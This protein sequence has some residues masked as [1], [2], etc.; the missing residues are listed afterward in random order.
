MIAHQIA[1]NGGIQQRFPQKLTLSVSGRNGHEKI[2][3][4]EATTSNGPAT[5]GNFTMQF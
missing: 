2:E 4:A 1:R 5:T 3:E